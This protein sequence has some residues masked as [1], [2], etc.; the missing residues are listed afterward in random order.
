MDSTLVKGVAVLEWLVK[1]QRSCRV[2]E[3]AQALGLARSNA[4]RTLQT[5]TH[6]GFVAQD[7]ASGTYHCTLRL[8]EWGSRVAD[9]FDVRRV[10]RANLMELGRSTLETIHL[11]VLDG[12]EI[13]YLEKIDSPQ[14]VRAYSE[15]GGRAPAHCVATGKALMAHAGAAALERL[16]V[17]LPRPT[18]KTVA[19]LDGLNAQFAQIRR[20]GYAVNREEWRLGVSG[21]GAPIFDQQGHAIAAIGLSAPSVRMD[22]KRIKALGA[23]LATSAL[24]ITLSLGG[25]VPA[26]NTHKKEIP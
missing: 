13:V 12:A 15:V 16:A 22:D 5:W 9:G 21:L 20:L 23:A 7:A 4:H 25:R 26:A 10:A 17:P 2:S 14:P 6:L 3:V 8:F 19:D 1:Q 18:P 11:S 24:A